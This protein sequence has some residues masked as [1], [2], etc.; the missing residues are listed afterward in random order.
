MADIHSNLVAL[1]EV[2]DCINKE[3]VDGFLCAGDIVGYGPNPNECIE[4]MQSLKGLSVVV[5]NH[6]WAAL[7]LEDISI[8][9]PVA[10]EAILW[11]GKQLTKANQEYLRNL[12]YSLTKDNFTLVHGTLCDPLEEYMFDSEIFKAHLLRQT[13]PFCFHGH[14]HIPFYFCATQE[15]ITGG[16]LEVGELNLNPAF[17]YAINLGS[18]GQPRDGT[19]E[20]CYAIFDDEKNK[21]EFRRTGYNIKKVQEEMR[22]KNLPE[23]LIERLAFGR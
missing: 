13:T 22:A 12:P 19:P 6:D 20:A 18:V 9:N 1:Q 2:I 4:V 11:T 3:E 8:F 14:T 23:Y 21:L 5:G 16:A 10:Q 7:G 17:R 15:Q